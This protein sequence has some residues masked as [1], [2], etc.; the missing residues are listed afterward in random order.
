MKTI[1]CK[2]VLL[3]VLQYIMIYSCIAQD[4]KVSKKI[5]KEYPVNSSSKLNIENK[6]GN[7]QIINW[8]KPEVNITANITVTA[9]S[10]ETAEEALKNIKVNISNQGNDVKVVTDFEDNLSNRVKHFNIEYVITMPAS[11]SLKLFNKYGD[12]AINDLSGEN[13]IE[14]KYGNLK[15]NKLTRSNLKPL[16]EVTLGYSNCTID[17]ANWLKLTMKYSKLKV[18]QF[19]ALIVVSKYSK[20]SLERGSSLVSESKYDTYEIDQLQNLVLNAEYSN[21]SLNG[22]SKKFDLFSKYTDVKV[23]SLSPD[24][25]NIN[26]QSKY[27]KISLGIDEHASYKLKGNASYCEI[28]YP[29]ENSKVKRIS[30]DSRTTL[31]GYIGTPNSK[32]SVVISSE[33]G[34]VKLIK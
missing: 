8:N 1:K 10:K 11:L 14:V 26:V 29:K 16:S 34:N 2:L 32:Q 33:Y 13:N 24:F 5:I 25:E 18:N 28:F 9:K 7:I 12:V 19:K 15:I 20:I 23:S 4:I 27:G 6:Y 31:D 21:Y 17:N 22:L 3:F 30:N